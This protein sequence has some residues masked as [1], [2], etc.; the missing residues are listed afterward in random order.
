MAHG[1]YVF[2]A[3]GSGTTTFGR[4]LAQFLNFAHLD[5]DDYF[6]ENTDVPF[7]ISRPRKRRQQMLKGDMVKHEK[8]VVS[9]SATGWDE[10]FCPYY[11]LAIFVTTPTN[12]RIERLKKR[13][14]A[15]F[16]ERI[17]ENGD[18][19]RNHLEFLEWAANYDAGGLDM[20]SLASHE[21]W[22]EKCPCPIIRINGADD[23]RS[24]A[25]TIAERFYTKSDELW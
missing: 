22:I 17:G 4:E 19:Q 16:G 24:S 25:K 2:G 6:W 7:T 14:Y 18:M 3:S 21:Q 12:I 23:Y 20:R 5:I 15:E 13:E 10:P 8:F 11:D 1:I 9:G